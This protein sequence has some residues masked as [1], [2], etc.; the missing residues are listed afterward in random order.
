MFYHRIRKQTAQEEFD[1]YCCKF[2]HYNDFTIPEATHRVFGIEGGKRISLPC[3]DNC[4]DDIRRELRKFPATPVTHSEG[5]ETYDGR[6]NYI[7]PFL[8]FSE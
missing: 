2:G 8:K 3:C 1:G 7:S 5:D 4:A 6:E